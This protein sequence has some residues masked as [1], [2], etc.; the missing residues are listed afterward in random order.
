[1]FAFE[2]GYFGIIITRRTLLY[3]VLSITLF[4]AIYVFILVEDGVNHEI[5]K[6]IKSSF[7]DACLTFSCFAYST[8]H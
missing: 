7:P 6:L 2:Y 5:G 1:M 8:N 3:I 4:L